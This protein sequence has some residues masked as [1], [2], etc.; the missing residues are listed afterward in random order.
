M[1]RKGMKIEGFELSGNAAETVRRSGKTRSETM[2]VHGND[3][4]PEWGYCKTPGCNEPAEPLWFSGDFPDD[5]DLL[6]CYKHTGAYI[7]DMLTERR[8]LCDILS[9][10]T[11]TTAGQTLAEAAQSFITRNEK[12]TELARQATYGLWRWKRN[13]RRGGSRYEAEHGMEDLG[14]ATSDF[15]ELLGLD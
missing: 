9:A 8:A 12:L 1:K 2:D 13:Q 15:A 6:L 5:P 4:T 10:P 11:V 7:G 3:N 14:Q